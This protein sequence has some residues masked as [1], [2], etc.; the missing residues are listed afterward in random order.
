LFPLSNRKP[1]TGALWDLKQEDKN[2]LFFRD[3]AILLVTFTLIMVADIY[4][5]DYMLEKCKCFIS[6]GFCFSSNIGVAHHK[7]H[8]NYIRVVKSRRKK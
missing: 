3:T 6:C 2:D 5:A 4:S 8:I 1:E 7:R